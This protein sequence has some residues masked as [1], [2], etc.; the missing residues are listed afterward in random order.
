MT[1]NSSCTANKQKLHN[2]LYSQ[3]DEAKELLQSE[4][5]VQ[6]RLDPKGAQHEL[7]SDVSFIVRAI[8]IVTH[9]NTSHY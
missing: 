2:L 4:D 3:P 1:G 7:N 6:T 9:S 8:Y 5:R